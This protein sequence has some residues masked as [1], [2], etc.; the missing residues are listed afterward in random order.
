MGKTEIQ[1]YKE[2]KEGSH[3]AFD[4]FF[5]KYYVPLYA[6]AKKTLSDAF[7]SEEIVQQV[8][9]DFWEN[10]LRT[11]IHSSVK[12]YLFKA[13]HNDILDFLKRG[14]Y[15]NKQ[16]LDGIQSTNE[17]NTE[18]Y[19]T[20]VETEFETIMQNAFSA[21]PDQCRIVFFLNRFD[22]L[23]YKEIAIKQSI[24]VKT[25]E[26]QIGKALKIIREKLQPYFITI[27]PIF[28]ML[29]NL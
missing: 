22:G 7:V 18:F 29:T 28:F 6:Y 25:V 1:Y 11:N 17:P 9:I 13:V 26:N 12:S 15:G 10:R 20:L 4:Y 3:A 8:F 2:L 27:L 16:S 5:E 14:N 23:S 19:D 24:S 21:L